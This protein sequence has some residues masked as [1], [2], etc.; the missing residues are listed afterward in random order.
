N[1][2]SGVRR[3]GWVLPLLALI[4]IAA[5]PPL[6]DAARGFLDGAFGGRNMFNLWSTLSRASMLL[7]MGMAV[8]VAFRSGLINLGGE[9]QLIFGGVAA[10]LIG[11]HAPLPPGLLIV[12]ALVGAMLAGGL[13]ALLAQVL[14]R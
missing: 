8:L 2:G 6:R 5:V 9:G 13:W 14:D 11:I 3:L 10:A 7:G 4:V 12:A 1:R